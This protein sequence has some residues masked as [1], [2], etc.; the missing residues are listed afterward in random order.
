MPSVLGI[1]LAET[2]AVVARSANLLALRPALVD[3]KITLWSQA[4]G[5][6]RTD[7]ARFIVVRWWGL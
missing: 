1:A 3:S 6:D 2:P 4:L 5:V 7:V